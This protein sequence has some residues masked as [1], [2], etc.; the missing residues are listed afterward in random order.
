MQ[1][2]LMRG[3]AEGRLEGEQKRRGES[4]APS[5]AKRFGPLSPTMCLP[6]CR[7]PALMSWNC[8]WTGHW[9]PTVWP[10]VCPVTTLSTGG[11]SAARRQ[12]ARF[13][14]CNFVQYPLPCLFIHCP[15]SGLKGRGYVGQSYLGDGHVCAGW[16]DFAGAGECAG[17]G[18]GRAGRVCA[19]LAACHR[20]QRVMC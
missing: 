14:G 4:T 16:G 20:R 13:S 18:G 15:S 10:G 2:G 9:M 17:H 1:R 12:T 3:R 8:G 19:R 6:V 7:A 11:G 5:V